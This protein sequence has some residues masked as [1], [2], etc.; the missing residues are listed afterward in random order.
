MEE[1]IRYRIS[2]TLHVALWL[3]LISWPVFCGMKKTFLEGFTPR[4]LYDQ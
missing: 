2:D 4:E 1:D 3:L